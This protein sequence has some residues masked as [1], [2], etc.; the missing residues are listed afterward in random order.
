MRLTVP[1]SV[2]GF[3]ESKIAENEWCAAAGAVPSSETRL[4]IKARRRCMALP[5]DNRASIVLV[6]LEV[7]LPAALAAL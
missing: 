5:P 2:T 7:V 4:K 6:A 3:A 1:V